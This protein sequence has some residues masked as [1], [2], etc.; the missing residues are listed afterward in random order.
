MLG[1]GGRGWTLI[2]LAVAAGVLTGGPSVAVGA[3]DDDHL[4]MVP[5]TAAGRAALSSSSGRVVASYDAF[6]LVEAGGRTCPGWSPRAPTCATTCARC[7]SA[8]RPRIRRLPGPRSLDKN[9]NAALASAG[10]GATGLAVVQY[11]GPIKDDVGRGVE[12]KAGVHVVSYMAQ[13]G[14]LVS[15][16]DAA[17]RAPWP[18]WPPSTRFVRAVTPYTAADKQ[19]PGLRRAGQPSASSSRPWRARP[20][21]PP[22]PRWPPHRR[23]RAT[24][25]P[26]PGSS[27]SPC[28]RRR[29]DPGPGRPR[30]RGLGRARR[31]AGPAR[32]AGGTDR[33]RQPQRV[34]P[35]AAGLGLHV[36]LDRARFATT[37]TGVDR[38]HRRGRRQGRRP[39]RRPAL[40]PTSP[41]P[42]M[43]DRTPRRPPRLMP[44]RAT[45]AGTAPTSPRSPPAGTPGP[46]PTLED[47]QGFNYGL[48]ISAVRA[49]SAR[50]RS[51]TA[52]ATS[53]S[54]RRS[55]PCT[56]PP[57]PPA[58][59]C[60]TTR[61]GARVGGAYDSTSQ[62]F[63]ALVRDA[64]PA[65]S[66]N[67]GFA[68]VVSSGNSGAGGNTIG[69]PGDGQERHHGGSR[70]ERAA[71]RRD[72]WLRRD[73]HRRRQRPRHHRLLQPR[74]D[75]R[76]PH[77]ARR[78]GT[79]HARQRRP[80]PD[81]RGLQRH[82]DLQPAVPG[83]QHALQPHLGDVPGRAGGGGPGQPAAELLP[84]EVGRWHDARQPGDD[85]GADGQHRDRP[86]RRPD[87][88]AGGINGAAPT[89]TQGWGRINLGTVL[90][91]VPRQVA[92]QKK[93]IGATGATV[94][95]FYDVASA[96]R[97]TRFTLAF[98]DAV[99]P[100][101][102]TR[103]RQ[104]P[105]P[106]GH[107]RRP[108]LQ[109][110][111]PRRRRLA[112][113]WDGRPAE[114]RRERRAARR[115]HRSGQGVGGGDEH[116]RRRGPGQ[117]RHHRSGL[118]ARGRQRGSGPEPPGPR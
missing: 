15:G 117:R 21:T 35:A 64:R 6:T 52:P 7:G 18:S 102:G 114:Q 45:A 20:A 44:T 101:V 16:D 111:R 60:R 23:R 54:R 41:E 39:R 32:R 92:D 37:R 96:A 98:T 93:V 88:G 71:D 86:G 73:R 31:D 17:A 90:N 61:G 76:R 2:V 74:P 40:T 118:R 29:E 28:A 72:R 10:R 65:T 58:R 57:T 91:G 43:T 78:R 49:A 105:R 34:L 67:Q 68:E 50:R 42:A 89:Q 99:G 26:S 80:A 48:G 75:R 12:R 81:G 77:E 104:R 62:E 9:G 13:N 82:R 36:L 106:P 46:G 3:D 108:R 107:R 110:Q 94:N 11:V 63:D 24:G 97:P 22:G 109:G 66:G 38:R 112:A 113:G 47:A 53:T 59:G 51:S 95:S 100:T 70:R 79:G 55:P 83:R 4:V 85:Q 30:R 19:L 116:R 69:Q 33:R 8:P 5:N 27:S 25:C 103:L 56:P 1:I 14:Q 84:R 115:R 87:D